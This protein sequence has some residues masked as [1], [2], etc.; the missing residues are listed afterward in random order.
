MKKYVSVIMATIALAGCLTACSGKI[1]DTT[2]IV[3]GDKEVAAVTNEDGVIVRDDNGQALVVVTD[4]EG[5]PVKGSNGEYETSAIEVS[6]AVEMGD[7]IENATFSVLVP[8]GWTSGNSYDTVT[9]N[10]SDDAQT[11]KVVIYT[12]KLKDKETPGAQLV[13]L[14]TG[15]AQVTVDKETA[16]TVTLAGVEAQRTRY[17]I[18]SD[19]IETRVL[20][21][22]SFEGPSASYGIICYSKDAKTADSVFEQVINTMILY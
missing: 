14:V 16:D 5:N 9:I 7:R 22:Y 15:N 11:N 18:T 10:S 19:A 6:H 2:K 17:D 12:D 8:D 4:D 21:Y 1:K 20:S 13:E 3:A